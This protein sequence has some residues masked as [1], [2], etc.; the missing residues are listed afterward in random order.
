[1][2]L[3]KKGSPEEMEI[4]DK[5]EAAIQSLSE[6]VKGP[7]EAYMNLMV[8]KEAEAEMAVYLGGIRDGIHLMLKINEIGKDGNDR[9]DKKYL[10]YILWTEII[11]FRRGLL[12][13]IW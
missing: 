10:W 12:W 13:K 9:T 7:I 1:M 11:L 4:I 3:E 6:E 5:G 8:Q 2:L